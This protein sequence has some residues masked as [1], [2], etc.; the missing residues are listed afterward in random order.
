MSSASRSN[1]MFSLNEAVGAA[2]TL[3]ALCERV[4]KSQGL[5]EQVGHLIPTGLRPH[6]HP[7]PLDDTEWCLLVDSAAAS[8]K[9][10]QM[11]PALLQTLNQNGAKI[12]AIR[13]KVQHARR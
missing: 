5:I 8:T 13:I 1:P 12:N 2:P 11:L 7:G 9:I 10:R 6:I 3:A 4:R